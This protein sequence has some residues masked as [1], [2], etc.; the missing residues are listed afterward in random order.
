MNRLARD[1]TVIYLTYRIEYLAPKT[2]GWLARHGFPRGALLFSDTRGFMKGSHEFKSEALG[3]LRLR[4]AG[5]IVGIGDKTSDVQAYLENGAEPY[6]IV[7]PGDRDAEALRDFAKSL[8][9]LPASVQAVS[10]WDEI[11]RG[12]FK[13]EK[14]PVGRMQKRLRDRADALGRGVRE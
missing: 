3:R 8:D 6:L 12:L 10:G 4:F 14:F 7:Q 1:F 13:G 2:Q 5:R 11:E 9:G